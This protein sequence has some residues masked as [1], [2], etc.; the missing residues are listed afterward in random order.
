M[1]LPDA[2]HELRPLADAMNALLDRLQHG[3]DA[4]AAFSAHASHELRTPL[5]TVS[6]ELE[7]GLRRPRSAA[8]WEQSAQTSLD[9]LR[10]LT[11]I[12]EALLRFAQADGARESDAVELEVADVVAELA[13]IH[14][15]RARDAGVRLIVTHAD[16]A[17]RVRGDAD[18]LLS[19]LGNLVGNAIRLTPRGGEVRISVVASQT[20]A[21]RSEVSVVIDDTGPGLPAKRDAL[22]VPFG[23]RGTP[24]AGFG[25]GLAIA[26]RIAARHDGALS[27]AEREGGGAT[28]TLRLPLIDG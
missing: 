10:R 21:G 8:E 16:A 6:N 3:Y 20:G 5:A 13:G 7:V 26:H 18:L 14:A 23:L 25:L 24:N 11:A 22:F 19:A 9:E 12:V 28:F 1:S 27:A 15:E 4:L 2:T 17:M